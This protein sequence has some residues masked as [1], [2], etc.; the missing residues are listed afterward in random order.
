M[1]DNLIP[2]VQSVFYLMNMNVGLWTPLYP[3]YNPL[4]K[5]DK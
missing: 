3:C 4:A 5:V 2:P 1:S